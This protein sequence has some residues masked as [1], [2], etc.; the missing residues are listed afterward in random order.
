ML[1][2]V[3]VVPEMRNSINI[4]VIMRE[5]VTGAAWLRESFTLIKDITLII[6]ELNSSESNLD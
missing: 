6:I 5:F 4:T 1:R 3:A 2:I